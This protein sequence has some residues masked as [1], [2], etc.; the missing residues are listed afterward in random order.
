M[1]LTQTVIN[2]VWLMVNYSISPAIITREVMR[3]NGDLFRMTDNKPRDFNLYKLGLYE[4]YCFI[5]L[6]KYG[7][8]VRI[9]TKAFDYDQIS[10][11]FTTR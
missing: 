10:Y 6:S 1:V 7:W 11:P 2:G 5:A 3:F 8:Y 9:T 4:T